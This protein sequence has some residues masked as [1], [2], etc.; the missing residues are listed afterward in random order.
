LEEE[1]IGVLL[2]NGDGT[3]QADTAYLADAP[4]WVTAAD[5]HGDS[6]LDLVVANIA[7]PSPISTGVSVLGGNGDGTFQDAVFYPGGNANRFAA[8]GDF[9]GD[10]KPDIVY[11]ASGV[12]DV[13][14]LL[15]TGVLS[16][17]PTTPLK[18]ATQV[19]NTQ[20]ASQTVTL[21][22]TGTA[23]VSVRS[24][25]VS[26]QFQM[27]NNCNG[28]IAAGASCA[29]SVISAPTSLGNHIG[30]VTLRDSASSK[31]QGIELSSRGT[32]IGLSPN[33]M[34][35]GLQ[36]TGTTSSPQQLTITNYG[37]TTVTVSEITLLSADFTASNAINCEHALAP[38]ATCQVPITFSPKKRGHISATF[39]VVDNGGGSPEIARLT[40][41]GS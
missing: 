6:K 28:T 27:S 9:N 5:L 18:F 31:P 41:T 35:F 22:N 11:A 32:E 29:V 12:T 34:N 25:S 10:H 16:F 24:V 8:V 40:G 4:L 23:A 7:G 26:G 2:G 15:N 14:L 37:S 1:A 33:P 17:S 13:T 36:K 19:L 20:S 3:F 21:T 39:S 38:G 30:M